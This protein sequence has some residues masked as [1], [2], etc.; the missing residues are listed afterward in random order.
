MRYNHRMQDDELIS[1]T[2]R[3]KHVKLA[4]AAAVVALVA[5]YWIT[6]PP[7][8]L[9]LRAFENSNAPNHP[10]CIVW[11]HLPNAVQGNIEIKNGNE[12][13]FLGRLLPDQLNRGDLCFVGHSGPVS[14]YMIVI[15]RDG[16]PLAETATL[17]ANTNALPANTPTGSAPLLSPTPTHTKRATEQVDQ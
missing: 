11:D 1:L 4:L 17:P 12:E 13:P 5:W 8:K 6:R 14:A 15:R 2:V 16:E 9:G 3:R 7:S 10:F